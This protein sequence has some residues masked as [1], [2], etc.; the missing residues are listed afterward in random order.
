M[1]FHKIILSLVAAG[2]LLGGCKDE[3]DI[4]AQGALSE[5]QLATK[6][7]VNALLLAAYA[8]LDGQQYVNNSVQNLSGSNAWEASPS[9][10]VFGSI[11]GGDAHKGSDG[12]D[13]AAVDAIAKFTADPTNSYFNSKWRTVYEGI[14]RTNSV[15]KVMAETTDMTE[16]EK[17][18]VAAETRFL[19][20]HFY[21]ELKKIFGNIPWID[22]TIPSAEAGK[23][24]NTVDV[25]PKIED[26]FQYAV[27][28]LPPTQSDVGRV[29]KWAA[30]TYLAKTYL[31]QKKYPE[32]KALFDQVV[33][34][35]V[36]SNGL[37][38]A[39]VAHF[40]DNFDAA[41][42]NNSESVFAIQMV[43]NDGSGSIANAN[44]GDML[45]FPYGDSPFRCCGFFQPTQDLVNSYRTDDDGLPYLD[46]YNNHPV[47]SDQ[48]VASNTAF[49]EDTG[50]LDPRLDWTVGRRGLPYLDWGHHPGA[51]W[52]RSPGQTYAGP[53]SPKKNIYM[54]ATQNQYSDQS[55][56]AP[57]TAINLN[58]IRFADVL[59]MAAEVEAQLGNYNIAQ[60]YVN[61][62][63][64]RAADPQNFVYE[65]I[66]A[67]K[68][69]DGYTTTPAATYEIAEYPAGA[70][71]AGGR[72]FSLK[73]IYFER[74]LELAME[75]HRFFDLVRWEI[76]EDALTAFF[77]Y[78][79]T[80]TTDI[81]GGKFIAGKNEHFPIP[82]RQIDLSTSNGESALTQNDLY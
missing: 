17:K 52:I 35:G 61:Q 80:I 43:A 11:A 68:P 32:A 33:S 66:D 72:E 50:N 7:G 22:E 1:R 82:Q 5:D 78:E 73:A 59:L 56:W 27:D 31:Y 40:H 2:L 53:Y 69:L 64:A 30:M 29:N 62:V 55:V 48:G 37:K 18:V 4:P 13:Q 81:Q 26:D 25:W 20:A 41:T 49:T 14:N 71:T 28:N 67:S 23:V 12:S 42:E 39:L 65:Y 9:N 24:V 51:N 60:G 36:T 15:L 34:Q 63:R 57:G 44:Q 3:L 16:D 47:K 75:G 76:A 54:Q 45:N 10:W 38:Y 79:S 77:T 6:A 70:F 58:V 74:K 46:E 19:R 21:F 8:A